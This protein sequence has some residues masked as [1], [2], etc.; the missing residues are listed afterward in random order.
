MP[1]LC[2]RWQRLQNSGHQWATHFQLVVVMTKFQN[3]TLQLIVSRLLTVKISSVNALHLVQREDRSTIS[4]VC[5][6]NYAMI[7]SGA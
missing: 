2:L 6:K 3:G 7:P 1:R 5:G 4:T